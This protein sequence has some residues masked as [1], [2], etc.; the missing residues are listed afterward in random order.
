MTKGAFWQREIKLVVEFYYFS[1][2]DMR[3]PIATRSLYIRTP[4]FILEFSNKDYEIQFRTEVARRRNRADVELFNLSDDTVNKLNLPTPITAAWQVTPKGGW[5]KQ[6]YLHAGYQN[7]TGVLIYGTAFHDKTF[8]DGVNKITSITI[9][10]ISPSGFIN[11]PLTKTWGAGVKASEVIR[12]IAEMIGFRT[13]FLG[14]ALQY[15]RVFEYG[16]SIHENSAD[17]AINH[18]VVVEMSAYHGIDFIQSERLRHQ[19]GHFN[20]FVFTSRSPLHFGEAHT[21]PIHISHEHGLLQPP[22]FTVVS[23]G[24]DD[25]YYRMEFETMLDYRL[26]QWRGVYIESP[27]HTGYHNIT[28]LRHICTGHEYVS[29]VTTRTGGRED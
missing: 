19:W 4:D 18:I 24:S 12:D 7:D 22:S 27:T 16:W 25:W 23:F 14:D 1:D 10:G 13:H 5:Q 28:E 15:D 11:T 9:D 6:A 3:A 26:T 2:A 20:L 8:R 29:R 17:L 21:P